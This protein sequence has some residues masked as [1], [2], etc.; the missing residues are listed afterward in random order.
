VE[1]SVGKRKSERREGRHMMCGRVKEMRRKMTKKREE[2][3][4]VSVGSGV[5]ARASPFALIVAS[6]CC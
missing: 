2:V 1:V 6:S 3:R 4:V 5:V